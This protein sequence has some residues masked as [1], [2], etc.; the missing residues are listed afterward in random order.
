MSTTTQRFN[1][2]HALR[3]ARIQLLFDHTPPCVAKDEIALRLNMAVQA[4][5]DKALCHK[6]VTDLLNYAEEF[7]KIKS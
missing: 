3:I 7:Y 2:N 6:L 5:G 1:I 4:Q